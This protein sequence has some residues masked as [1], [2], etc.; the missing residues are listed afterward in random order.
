MVVTIKSAPIVN[1]GADIF[2]CSNN[3]NATLSGT[4]STG[5]AQWSSSG[6]GTFTPNNT[7]LNAT[8]VSSAS[9]IAGG[10]VTLTLTSNNN[11]NCLAVA[12]TLTIKYTAPPTVNAGA[13]AS[14]CA[15]NSAVALS[16]T[17]ST[18]AGA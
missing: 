13:G 15:N 7:T 11:T 6:T 5:A 14:V 2:V 10:V 17:S 12:D 3:A 9:D 1:G 16:G 18:G 4:S 8:Y